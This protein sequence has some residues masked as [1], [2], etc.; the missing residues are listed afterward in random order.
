MSHASLDHDDKVLSCIFGPED[1]EEY[2]KNL[3]ES[4]EGGEIDVAKFRAHIAQLE[5]TYHNM[6]TFIDKYNYLEIKWKAENSQCP[7]PTT[8][9]AATAS[10]DSTAKSPS[11]VATSDS[12]HPETPAQNADGNN[13]SE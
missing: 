9:T 13:Q 2:T 6:K 1:T 3:I 8:P 5:G 4:Y 10:A 11:T 12:Q 7:N